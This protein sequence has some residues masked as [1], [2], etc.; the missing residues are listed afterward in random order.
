MDVPQAGSGHS[1]LPRQFWYR[2]ALILALHAVAIVYFF[3]AGL[4]QTY[5]LLFV[6]LL[7][8][9]VMF[10]LTHD[11]DFEGIAEL[12]QSSTHT[13]IMICGLVVCGILFAVLGNLLRS[14]KDFQLDW[15]HL[16]TSTLSIW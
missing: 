15:Y 11:D 12:E 8:L 2:V 16:L 13:A 5:G 6:L 14:F 4:D 7:Y 9:L 10:A 3:A 1:V